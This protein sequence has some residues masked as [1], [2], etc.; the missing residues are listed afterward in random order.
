MLLSLAY[1][2]SDFF[3]IDPCDASGDEDFV[4][5]VVTHNKQ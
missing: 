3:D 5:I 1:V 2:F 4:G